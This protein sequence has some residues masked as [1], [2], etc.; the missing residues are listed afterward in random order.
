MPNHSLISPVD[1]L[2][3]SYSFRFLKSDS[4]PF[5]R[6]NANVIVFS[7]RSCIKTLSENGFLKN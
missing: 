2:P 3:N 5:D 7:R 4:I 6:V 1:C